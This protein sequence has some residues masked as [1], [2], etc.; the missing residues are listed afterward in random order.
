MENA[1]EIL[2]VI[3]SVFLAI[4][5]ILGI[6]L[7][8][9]LIKLT[10]TIKRI[11]ETAEHAMGNVQAAAAVFKNAAGPLAAGK[12]VMNIVD[13]VLNKRKGKGRS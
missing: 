3:L 11:A 13:T 7:T 4:F 6:V 1:A 12:F 5:L 8:I 10:Q 9:A 2:V